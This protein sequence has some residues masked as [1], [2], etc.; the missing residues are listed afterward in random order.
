MGR[1]Q[2]RIHGAVHVEVPAHLHQ[3][4]RLDTARGDHVDAVVPHAAGGDGD[5]LQPRR[6]VAVH[7]HAGGRD[8]AAGGDGGVARDVET[9]G[10]FRMPR[11]QHHVIDLRPPRA[12]T[13]ERVT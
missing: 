12:G 11:A 1:E 13:L 3:R 10:T 2:G 6:A 4:D 9:R 5:R 7:G 8:G